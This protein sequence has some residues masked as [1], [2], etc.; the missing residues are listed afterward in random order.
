M[1]AEE[2]IPNPENKPMVNHKD[3]N[4]ANNRATNLEWVTALENRNHA[5]ATGLFDDKAENNP[6]SKLSNSD[7]YRVRKLYLTEL[8]TQDELARLFKVSQ[9]EIGNIVRGDNW[10][11]LL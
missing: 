4:K 11:T 2:F 6:N 9:P 1:V 10:R 8:V 7:V 3:G 5:I